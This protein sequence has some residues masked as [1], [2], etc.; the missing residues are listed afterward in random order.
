[1]VGVQVGLVH[2]RRLLPGPL[3][4]AG[5]ASRV[6]QVAGPTSRVGQVVQ[7]VEPKQ[8]HHWVKHILERLIYVLTLRSNFYYKT[9]FARNLL[10]MQKGMFY[11]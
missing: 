7:T 3:D 4:V 5:P 9:L 2:A 6:G 8:Q 1:M 11:D 10:L